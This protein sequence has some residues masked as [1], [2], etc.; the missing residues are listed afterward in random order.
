MELHKLHVLKLS[1]SFVR[2]GHSIAGVLPGVGGYAVGFADAA[3]GHDY[4][5][6]FQDNK[7]SLLAPVSEGA[8][9]AV[10]IFQ[11]ADDGAFHEDIKAHSHAA[12]LKRANHLQASTVTHM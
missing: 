3:S 5:F 8:G 10:A 2:K 11:Q 6:R 4:R 7:A 1:A 12:I 9:D